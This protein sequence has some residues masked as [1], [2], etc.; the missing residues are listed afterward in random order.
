MKNV[1]GHLCG[2]HERVR[3]QT[4]QM[5]VRVNRDLS[6]RI[7]AATEANVAPVARL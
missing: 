6:A 3:K 7:G 2:P 4:H 5:F 1:S